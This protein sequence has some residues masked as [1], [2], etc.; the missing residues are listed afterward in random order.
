MASR[1]RVGLMAALL[2]IGGQAAMLAAPQS[3]KIS[4]GD[5]L[6]IVVANID[7]GATDFVVDTEGTI[8]YPYLGKIKVAGMTS[9][10]LAAK[11]GADLVTERC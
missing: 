1:F 9:T 8:N 3:P 6:K 4:T 11:V 5:Q 7:M 10:E 2:A